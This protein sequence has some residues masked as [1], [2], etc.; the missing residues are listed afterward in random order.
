MIR[1][2]LVLSLVGAVFVVPSAQARPLRHGKPAVVADKGDKDDE[3]DDDN[4]ND[5]SDADKESKA[6]AKAAEESDDDDDKDRE[7]G[8][9]PADSQE[10]ENGEPPRTS[11]DTLHASDSEDEDEGQGEDP[12]EHRHHG[13]TH[14]EPG[15]GLEWI[16]SRAR[17]RLGLV[18]QP[19]A[20]YGHD[21]IPSPD[22]MDLTIRRARVSFDAEV[23]HGTGFHLELQA[24]NLQV[25]FAD[26]YGRWAL[27]EHIEIQAG[28]LHAPGGLERDTSPFDLPFLERSS[29]ASM[30]RDREVGLKLVGHQDFQFWQVSITRDA[31][32]GI[33]G[34][35]PDIAINYP[36]GVDPTTVQRSA[37]TWNQAARVGTAPSDEFAAGLDWTLRIRNSQADYGDPAYAPGGSVFLDARPFRGT[38]VR[39]G[40]DAAI[41][42]S[43]FRVLMEASFRRDGQQLSYDGQSGIE[44]RLPGHEWWTGGYLTVG[45]SPYGGYGR[46]VDGAPLQYGWELLGRFEAMRVKPVDAFGST[47]YAE[48][49]GWNWVATRQIRIQLDATLQTFGEFDQTTMMDDAGATRFY[50]ELWATWRL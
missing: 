26:L 36:R 40:A 35:D 6:K 50:G 21:S 45:W 16:A 39:I 15:L 28:F 12:D 13:H 7:D 31:P 25:G 48:T 3:D 19:M 43:H 37:T 1:R 17:L 5:G 14:H 44:S 46:A 24:K 30:T 20:R 33:G 29:L 2:A 9:D 23:S 47:L 34:D 41:S 42:E 22:T 38:I 32:L 11:H 8:E 27:D 4:D 18:V 10:G 49:L